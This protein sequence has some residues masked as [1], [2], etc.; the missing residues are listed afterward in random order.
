MPRLFLLVMALLASAP[1]LADAVCPL[2][3]WGWR[4]SPHEFLLRDQ[5]LFVADGRGI[6]VYD[7]A[8]PA[9]IRRTAVAVTGAPA[10]RVAV[11]GSSLLALT[12]TSLEWFRLEADS[13]LPAGS[14]RLKQRV[15][16]VAAIDGLFLTAG[17]RLRL[18]S[19]NGATMTELFS[20]DLESDAIDA[21][22]VDGNLIFVGEKERGVNVFRI[23]GQTLAPISS[24]PIVA[25][26]L[27]RFE[28][29]LYAASGGLGVSVVDIAVPESPKFLRVI[30]PDDIDYREV[31]LAGDR[32]FAIDQ[33]RGSRIVSFDL[34]DPA[35]PEATG[36]FDEPVRASTAGA[37]RLYVSGV[38]HEPFDSFSETGAAVRVFD[39][40]ASEPALIGEFLDHAGPLTGVGTDGSFAY[41]ADPPFFR[42]IDLRIAHQPREVARLAIDDSSD[43]V[44]LAGTMALVYGRGNVHMIDLADPLRPRYLGVY[45][46]LGSPPNGA[47]MA[48]P[49]LIEDNRPTGFHVVDISDPASPF[50]IGGLKNDGWGQFFGV[51]AR[52][53]AAYALVNRGIKVIDL[54]NPHNPIFTRIIVL[55]KITDLEIAPATSTR[56]ELLVALDGAHL[57]F[58]SLATLLDPIELSSITIPDSHEVAVG[59]DI[60]WVLTRDRRIVRIDFSDPLQPRITRTDGDFFDPVQVAVSGSTVAVADTW[61]LRVMSDPP[62]STPGTPLLERV[63][64]GAR[65]VARIRWSGSTAP[66]FEIEVDDDSSFASPERSATSARE[67]FVPLPAGRYVRVRGRHACATEAWS[68]TLHLEH[69][70]GGIAFVENGRHVVVSSASDPFDLPLPIRNDGS[71]EASAS[72]LG[73]GHQ[74]ISHPASVTLQAGTSGSL[75]VTIT[76]ALITGE[77]RFTIVLEGAEAGGSYELIVSVVSPERRE[78]RIE[79]ESLLIPGVA[80]T[81]GAHDTR[82]KSNLN[83]GCRSLTGCEIEIGFI[84]FGSGDE[85]DWI[86]ISLAALQSVVI[87]DVIQ[88]LF[89]RESAAGTIELRISSVLDI[90]ASGWTYN[91]GDNGRYGQLIPAMLNE[92][93]EPASQGSGIRRLLGVSHGAAVRT[94]IGLINGGTSPEIVR[95]VALGNDGSALG[96]NELQLGPRQSL[97]ASFAA[98]FGGAGITDGTIVLDASPAVIGYASRIDQQ[99]GDGV[100]SYAMRPAALS[101]EPALSARRSAFLI[102]SSTGGAAGSVWRTSVQLSNGGDETATVELTLVPLA[103]PARAESKHIELAP[104]ASFYS[105]DLLA[106]I[107]PHGPPELAALGWLRVSSRA[108]LLGWGQIYNQGPEGIFGQFVPLRSISPLTTESLGGGGSASSKSASPFR[109]RRPMMFPLEET[110]ERRT[111]LGLTEVGGKEALV[112]LNVYDSA[113]VLV[114]ITERYLAPY[115]AQLLSAPFTELGLG[116]ARHLRV[117]VEQLAGEGIVE[118]WASV[119]ENRTGDAVFIPAE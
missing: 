88:Q 57:R 92:A 81:E 116:G 102:V 74:A 65:S 51:I 73:D 24:I 45:R 63:A 41:L 98:L 49:Y 44:R 64:T 25:R 30:Q 23:E 77:G 119:V 83:L 47:A 80:A 39:V 62:S 111:N 87:E 105:S 91:D 106:E 109:G 42:V 115:V 54:S 58:F 75:P 61:A 78:P 32:L 17:A 36:S 104:G 8:N 59:G 71:A 52:P 96:S 79:G 55:S 99:T 34:T 103:D 114:G 6:A 18:L 4:G 95:L 11:G 90:A 68:N 13:L 67:I 112:Q 72:V 82:W 69:G 27:A 110:S 46:S 1:L 108:P 5:R 76:P 48:G 40:S 107:L 3:V 15:D 56:P 94:N 85:S 60:A 118:A 2:G 84:P 101:E 100:F 70:G 20:I 26:G 38:N 97:Q 31:L 28:S 19:I 86:E 10:R 21:L 93:T 29:Y 66:L 35:T 33:L 113:G 89:G 12:D 43:R 9:A 14:S 117:E 16:R 7:V 22:L 50:Q 37:S 53:G